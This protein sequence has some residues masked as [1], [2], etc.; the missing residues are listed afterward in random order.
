MNVQIKLDKPG[1][2][3]TNLD[4]ITGKVL[5]QLK[6]PV[7]IQSVTVKLEGESR[8]RLMAPPRPDRRDKPR[9]ELEIHKVH[10]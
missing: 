10:L 5:L 8:T 7:N 4:V 9:P 3:F 6:Y 1:E 2:V